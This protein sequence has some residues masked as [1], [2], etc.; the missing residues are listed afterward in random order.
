MPADF[1]VFQLNLVLSLFD[2]LL[3]NLN[4]QA[5]QLN[6]LGNGLVL[7]VVAHVLLLLLVLLE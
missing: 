1:I 7:A 2:F 5:L 6:F 3:G 4:F